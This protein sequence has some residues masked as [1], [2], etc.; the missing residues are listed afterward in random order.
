MAGAYFVSRLSS[1][2]KLFCSAAYSH[3]TGR[4]IDPV[5]SSSGKRAEIGVSE[6]SG[7]TRSIVFGPFE[8]DLATEELRR[9]G[10]PVRLPAQ[11]FQ[12]LRL[13][14]SR[15]GELVSRPEL[16]RALWPNDSFGDFEHGLNA[17]VNRLREALGD[18]ADTPRF[19]E[20]LPR[21]G[22]RFIATL[23]PPTAPEPALTPDR[24]PQSTDGE[25]AT[26]FPVAVASVGPDPLPQPEASRTL[27]TL[28]PGKT[29]LL[30]GISAFAVVALLAGWY[31]HAAVARSSEA[32]DTYNNSAIQVTPLTTLPG[33]EFGPTFSPDGSEVA[34]TWDGGDP[35]KTHPYDLY[36][37]VIGSERVEQLTHHPADWIL[38]AWS[39]DGR[40]IAFARKGPDI[41]GIFMVSALGGPE[42]KLADDPVQYAPPMSVSWSS[43]GQFL[44]Y[45]T[46]D[47]L[48]EVSIANGSVRPIATASDCSPSFTPA[49]S[50]DGQWIA[51]A[52][53]HD[54]RYDLEIIPV[55]GGPA[56]KLVHIDDIPSPM[57][58]TT[59]SK[60]VLYTELNRLFAISRAGGRP[61]PLSFAYAAN[62]PAVALRGDRLAYAQWTNNV[63]LWRISLGAGDS[64]ITSPM[65]TTSRLQQAPDI[66]PDGRKIAFESERSGRHEVWVSNADG[67]EAIEMGHFHA[68]SGTPRWSPDG[69]Y[70]VFDSRELGEASLFLVDPHEGVPRRID[71]GKISAQVPRWSRD[72]KWIYFTSISSNDHYSGLL[73][74][75]P[76]GGIPQS[77]TSEDTAFN[78]QE[79]RA[80]RTLYFAVGPTNCSIRALDL[81]DGKEHELEGMPP[82]EY[83]TDWVVASNGIYF[84]DSLPRPATI[85]FYDFALHRVTKRM[86]LPKRPIFWGGLALAPDETWLA[87]AQVDRNDSDLM[88][89]EPFR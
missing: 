80:G 15:P 7:T 21:R 26:F 45:G 74:V 34:F 58:W 27:R 88:L 35:D 28:R 46:E 73:K 51:F 40:N 62:H 37:K 36:V 23:D 81:I 5:H 1:H 4:Y 31:R 85:N 18:S 75:H 33:T 83:P 70:V 19:V 32:H 84:I 89:A 16:Q 86:P 49:F 59:D 20:T 47:G 12:V 54:L 38:S 29:W 14:L 78:G 48:R 65:T 30:F 76:E 22:Y 72:G 63:N 68:V 64:G 61:E 52:C 87:Y 57:A 55:S 42:R 67:S 10:Q 53:T 60:R 6:G 56:T 41:A 69:R 11:S 66:S 82:L 77:V 2:R 8:V 71:T 25:A 79:D 3:L 24:T 9:N 17:A 13:L 39:P 44:V 43:D 50:P